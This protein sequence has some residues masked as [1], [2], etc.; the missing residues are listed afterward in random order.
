MEVPTLKAEIR[1]GLGTRLSRR[2]RAGGWLPG[3]IYGHGETPEPISVSAH[4]LQVHLQHGAR[5][6][7]VEVDGRA[8]QYLI[9]EV[10]Y[11]HLQKDPVHFDLARVDVDERVQVEVAIELRGTPAGVN[12]GGILEPLRDT[13]KI[14]CL[15]LEIPDTLRPSVAHLDIGDTLL[16]KDLELPS[17]VVVLD[18]PQEK[19]AMVRVLAIH[20]EVEE[21]EEEAG[22]AEPERIGRVAETDTKDAD[23]NA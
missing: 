15:A 2:L 22:P 9:K 16:V 20:T 21:A 6:L 23:T 12:N 17:G 7:K 14:D 10:Q 13:L 4:D 11:D 19:V 5:I 1:R 18:D 3:I 8:S